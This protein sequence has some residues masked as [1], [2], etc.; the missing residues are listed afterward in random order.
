MNPESQIGAVDD[1]ISQ[2]NNE[3]KGRWLKKVPIMTCGAGLFSDGYLSG[4]IGPVNI[5]LQRIY[6]EEYTASRMRITTSIAFAGIVTGQLFFGWLVD[7]HSRKLGMVMAS[8]LLIFFSTLAAGAW[9]INGSTSGMF[10]ALTVYRFFLGIGIGG[11]Y[12]SGSV[13]C[14]EA[15]AEQKVG[16]RNRWFV[17]FTNFHITLGFATSALVPLILLKIIGM[18]KLE[19]LWRVSLAVGAVFPIIIF[20][21]RLHLCEGEQFKN[22]SLR[23]AGSVPWKLIIKFYWR[24]LLVVSAIWFIYNLSVYAFGLYFPYIIELITHRDSL[25]H[26]FAWSTLV[27]SFYLP[28]SLIGA[29]ASDWIGPGR[30]L[31]SGAFCQ[32]ILGFIL[33]GRFSKLKENAAAFVTLYG[34]FLTLGEFGP[35]NNI[36]LLAA[37]SSATAIRGKFYGIA[38]AS[39][40]VG[41]FIGAYF[42]TVIVE[43]C[44]GEDTDRGRSA[45]FFIASALGLIAGTLGLLF[46]KDLGQDAVQEEDERFREYLQSHGYDT[47]NLGDGETLREDRLMETPKSES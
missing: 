21:L 42:F 22:N 27:Q 20:W 39:G 41:G 47:Q 46:F 40:K 13:A 12:P 10:T 28:G 29:F 38:A 45:P 4:I 6:K 30:A 18:G 26:T 43:A 16:H 31:A 8:V 14:A 37:K 17:I 19:V 25:F 32:S 24:R 11:E 15:S 23:N 3:H 9:G 1:D 34:L 2:Q 44:G 7:Q 35:G 5:L 36:G 33:A